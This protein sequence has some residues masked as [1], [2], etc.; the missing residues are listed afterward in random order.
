MSDPAEMSPDEFAKYD[1]LDREE[2]ERS[3]HSII[4]CTD[5]LELFSKSIAN[6]IA[7]EKPNAQLLYLVCTSRH[8]EKPM[9]AAVKGPSA[10][11]KSQ[12]RA[13]VLNYQPK[14]SVIEFDTMSDKALYYWQGNKLSHKILSLGEASGTEERQAQEH[15]LRVLMSEGKA[16]HIVSEKPESG[17][18]YEA[19][20]YTID[21]PICF[22]VTTTKNELHPE[23][24]TRLLSL[25]INDS[26]AQ[27]RAVLEMQARIE[28]LGLAAA[29]V[30]F[31]P[32]QNFQRWLAT[33]PVDVV[34]PFAEVLPPLLQTVSV[35]LRRDFPQILKA[36]KAHALIHRQH[37]KVDEGGRILAELSDY[38]KVR[39]LMNAVVSANVGVSVRDEM[40]E[41]VEA[42]KIL[43]ASKA[44]D[45]SVTAFQVGQQLKMHSSTAH[46]R[47]TAAEDAGFVENME[48]RKYQKGKFRCTEQALPEPAGLLPKS[49]QVLEAMQTAQTCKRSDIC[50]E[51]QERSVCTGH[52]N[53][54]QTDHA[55]AQ[56]ATQTVIPLKDMDK[57]QSFARVHDLDGSEDIEERAAI[58]E[59]DAG[60]PREDAEAQAAQEFDG[61]RDMP[62]FLRRTA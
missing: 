44:A 47:L 43:T 17:R 8:F 46:R 36:I 26:E 29:N 6:F 55:N 28:G 10:A 42:V 58:L 15:L 45:Y 53:G 23:N 59:Y 37:R 56:S 41:T 27:T 21:G 7:G 61:K 22:I 9:H 62:G 40:R 2:Y 38:T 30:N 33:G 12:T 52:A 51:T 49:E 25:E 57:G 16:E 24:E 31:E 54:L 50:E 4:A 5:V 48:Q 20:T 18:G 39:D 19:K 13:A 34:V 60:L 14:E 35:R 1:E 3:A 32:W 11:G